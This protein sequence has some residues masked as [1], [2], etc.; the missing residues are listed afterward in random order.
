MSVT[1]THENYVASVRARVVSIAKSMLNDK[2]DFL[3]GSIELASL[4]HEAA[5]EPGNEDFMAFVAIASEVD[6]L[7]VG[8]VREHWSQEALVLHQ[9]Q[10]ENA[11]T[12]AKGFGIAACESLID[13]FRDRV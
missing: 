3:E 5:V 10:I 13:R 9:S 7:P 8:A 2:V 11:T 1:N 4:K 6:N 12:W